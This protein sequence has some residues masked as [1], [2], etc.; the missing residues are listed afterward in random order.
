MRRIPL[1]C[2]QTAIS[3][4]VCQSLQQRG[5]AVVDNVFGLAWN[6]KL[7]KELIRLKAENKMHLNSTHL[8]KQG[9]TELLEKQHV[10]EAELR[11]AVGSTNAQASIPAIT[12]CLA[13]HF[14][15]QLLASQPRVQ[16]TLLAC[17]SMLTEHDVL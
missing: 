3:P 9:G 15:Q 17:L 5:Y 8:V 7:K 13:V 6:A 10:Y 4:A 16:V 14:A 12:A 2:F 11:D 1:D